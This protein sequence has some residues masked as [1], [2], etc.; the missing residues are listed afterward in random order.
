MPEPY[1]MDEMAAYI[2][3]AALQRGI[4]PEIALKV[5]RSEG[6]QPG[7]WQSNVVKG[8]VREP[9]YGPFQLYKHGMGGDFQKA[10][11]LDPA[12]PSTAY[13]GVDFALDNAAKGGWG[14]WYGAKNAGIAPMQG[15]GGQPQG[16]P[17]LPPMPIPQPPSVPGLPAAGMVNQGM[18]ATQSI[19]PMLEQFK[20][21][22]Q[23]PMPSAGQISLAK[24]LPAS[25]TGAD[26]LKTSMGQGIESLQNM[27]KP[28]AIPPMPPMASAAPGVG[29]AASASAAPKLGLPGLGGIFSALAGLGGAMGPDPQTEQRNQQAVSDADRRRV[30]YWLR[31]QMEGAA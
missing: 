7:T 9:S 1:P 17:P 10:T 13:Q 23:Q 26:A 27:L 3:R 12:D 19:P 15:I 6:L 22:A 18:A 20:A 5:A 31:Q 14:P 30:E 16:T 24:H 11:G 8:G 28:P 4:D 25:L 21:V 29:A 2:R